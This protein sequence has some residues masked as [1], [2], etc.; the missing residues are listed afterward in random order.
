MN[1]SEKATSLEA[2]AKIATVVNLFK[3]EFPGVKA[4]LHP[5]ANDRETLAQTDPDSIDLGFNFPPGKTLVQLRFSGDRL[6]GIDAV[7]FGL[8][9]NQRWRFSTIA[10]WDFLGPNPPLKGFCDRFRLVCRE[11][12]DIFNG[13]EEIAS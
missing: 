3:Q 13:A 4:N 12:F 11:L 9:N 5:W 2:T 6:I 7:C 8:F 10:N 1:A